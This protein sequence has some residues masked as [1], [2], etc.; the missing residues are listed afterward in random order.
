MIWPLF[1]PTHDFDAEDFRELIYTHPFSKPIRWWK[2]RLDPQFDPASGKLPAGQVL[3]NRQEQFGISEFRAIIVDPTVARRYIPSAYYSKFESGDVLI[4]TMTRTPD[5]QA[6]LPLMEHDWVVPL[7]QP[8]PVGYDGADSPTASIVPQREIVKRGATLVPQAGTV[9]TVGAAVTGVGTTF[10]AI[11]GLVVGACIVVAGTGL[12]VAAIADDTHLTLESAPAA[13]W[14]ANAWALGVDKLIYPPV[15]R[16][17][18][19]WN[20]STIVDASTYQLS[21]DD[22]TIEWLAVAGTPAPGTRYSVTY[23]YYPT[24]V[25]T[26]IGLHLFEPTTANL[27][28]PRTVAGRLWKPETIGKPIPA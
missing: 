12:R 5:G 14:K 22:Q 8:D 27:R 3:Y 10:K 25:V 28:L 6:E 1:H 7:A 24:Y 15:A 26:N 16:I 19:V 9:S 13:P 20:G 11:T 4:T 21:D 2:A 23:S 18:E 17:E